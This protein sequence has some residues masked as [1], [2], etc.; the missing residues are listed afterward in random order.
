MPRQYTAKDF[1]G[2]TLVELLVVLAVA[3]I[4]ALIAVPSL[5]N[6]LQM[7]RLDAASNQFVATLS[8]ARSEAVKQGVQI[9]V[10]SNSGN[11]WSNGWVEC[12]APGTNLPLQVGTPLAAPMTNYGSTATVGFD[13]TGR[14]VNGGVAANFIFCADGSDP[15]KSMGVTVSLSGRVRIADQPAPPGLPLDNNEQ[16]MAAC[17]AP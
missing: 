2:F 9:N 5:Q 11:N 10:T 14:L 6:S 15:T 13:P 4:L 12:C 3:A 17:N 8:L 1:I 16:P 7:N